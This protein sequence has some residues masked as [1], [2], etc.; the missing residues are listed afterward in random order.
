MTTNK[1]KSYET[2]GT[3]Q[4]LMPLL[5]TDQLLVKA[6]REPQGVALLLSST[7]NTETGEPTESQWYLSEDQARWLI[8]NL[9]KGLKD[10]R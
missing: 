2:D 10:A 9:R 5:R 3:A 6:V 7:P 4:K 8:D 1:F